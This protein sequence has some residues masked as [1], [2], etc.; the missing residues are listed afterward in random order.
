MKIEF[1]NQWRYL[2]KDGIH[3]DVT[4][5]EFNIEFGRGYLG[6]CIFLLGLGVEIV[7]ER[8]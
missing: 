4:L 6:V 2:T 5:I 3:N 7:N 8:I 1:Y